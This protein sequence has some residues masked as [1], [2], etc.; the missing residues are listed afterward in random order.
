MQPGSTKQPLASIGSASTLSN[1][2]SPAIRSPSI[3][4]SVCTVSAAVTTVPPRMIFL[5]DTCRLLVGTAILCGMPNIHEPDFDQLREEPGFRA[6]RAYV[7]RQAGAQ[8]LGASI[9][10]V[11]PGQ[12]AYPYHYHFGEE[13]LVVVLS[14]EARLRTPAGER[15][16]GAGDVVSFGRGEAGAHQLVATGTAPLRFLSVSTNGDPDVVIYPDSGKVGACERRPDGG[17]FWELFRR[18][19]AVDYY[20]GERRD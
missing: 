10:E 12:A 18:A 1:D 6:R 11:E 13:E 14:G 20:D 8:R 5:P 9:W 4:T 15:G 3:R 7:G 17:G 2:P 19:D 16:V